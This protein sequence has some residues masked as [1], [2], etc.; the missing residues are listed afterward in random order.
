[1]R[2][3]TRYRKTLVQERAQ[4]AN[5]RH[6]VLGTA[7]LKRGSVA[8]DV[9]GQSGRAMLAALSGGEEDPATL[10]ELAQ[11][12]LRAKR[13]ELRRALAGRPR[14]HHRTLLAR[15]LAQLAFIDG[16]V[17]QVREA[18]DRCRAP[19]AAAV[20]L[21]RTIP[22]VGAT[23]AATI[24]A[25]S[26]TDLSRSPPSRHPPPGRGAVRATSSARASAAA[27]SRPRATPGC[28]PSRGRAPGAAPARGAIIS[29]RN[30]T[31]W[32]VAGAS[33]GRRW[34]S[35]QRARHRY[36]AVAHSVRV[37]AYQPLKTGQP[38]ADLGADYCDHRDAERIQRHH[39]KRLQQLGY[40][41]TLTP[42][43]VA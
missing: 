2:E 24:V 21:L 29:P 35:P 15:I 28:A 11:G 18:I 10:A 8:A 31:A 17:A 5:R 43:E 6:Q 32:P 39:G 26:G 25:E 38:Y 9:P 13:P 4:E 7:N 19:V 12:R 14:P 16:S 33:T 1:L 30:T 20:A 27:A 36:H 22:G 40:A 41:V 37:I 3:L 23:A 42:A 34:R